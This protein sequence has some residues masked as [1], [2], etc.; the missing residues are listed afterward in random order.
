MIA[1]TIH[2][3]HVRDKGAAGMDKLAKT[4][5][6]SNIFTRVIELD[7]PW[8]GLVRA[9]LCNPTAAYMIGHLAQP[10]SAV[11]CHSNGAAIL[12][13]AAKLTGKQFDYVCLVNPA[14]RSDLTIPYAR[15]VDTWFAPDDFPTLLAKWSRGVLPS[16]WGAQ[17][18]TGY[19]G[20]ALHHHNIQ[21]PTGSGHCG[22]FKSTLAMRRIAE[23]AAVVC[24]TKLLG[25]KPEE[26][27]LASIPW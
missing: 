19:T 15:H 13:R 17:G 6:D 8:F 14:L 20:Q 4:L 27:D 16:V 3:M 10:R 9:K 25:P 5:R 2:G 1:Y 22:V 23:R 26:W 11:F 21:L 24:N 7:Y 12:H 18:R